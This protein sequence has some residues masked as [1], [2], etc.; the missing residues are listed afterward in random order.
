MELP[1]S[2]PALIY[3]LFSITQ[4]IIDSIKGLYNTAFMKAI[5]AALITFLLNALCIQGLGIISWLI[6]FIPFIFMTF[7]I[8]M[9]LYTFGLD[10]ATGKIQYDNCK[11]CNVNP[12]VYQTQ[13]TFQS[14]PIFYTAKEQSKNNVK[15][16][17]VKM[18][19]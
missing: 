15:P 8:A 6:V 12:I 10:P 18:N 1:L 14:Y 5:V 11:N 4:I 3:L 2:G 19:G 7:I 17:C 13:P 9:L 16:E